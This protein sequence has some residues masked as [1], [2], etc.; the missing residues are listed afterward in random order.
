MNILGKVTSS[1]DRSNGTVGKVSVVILFGLYLAACAGTDMRTD[2]QVASDRVNAYLAANPETSKDVA[3][4]MRRFE[5]R[6]GMTPAE[7]VAVWG[8]PTTKKTWR[9]GQD[10]VLAFPCD[11]WPNACQSSLRLRG[12]GERTDAQLSPEAIFT[13]G[14]LTKWRQP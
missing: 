8:E 7:V 12:R 1:I 2:R 4:A 14:R 11:R 6:K 5:L 10:L 13:S 9:D 3:E